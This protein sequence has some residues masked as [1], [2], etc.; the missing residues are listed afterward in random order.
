[1]PNWVYNS[2]HCHGSE[3]DLDALAAFFEMEV[4]STTYDPK[5]KTDNLVTEKVPF[6]YQA[7]RNPFAEPYNIT[8][9]EYH[10]TNGFV[11]GERVGDTE[12]N[13]Y[14]WNSTHW[15]VKWDACRVDVERSDGLITYHFESPWG[16]PWED[17]MLELS[18]R[19]PTIAFTHR[20][21]EE[22]GWGGEY[23]FQNGQITEE[24]QWDIPTTHAEHMELDQT[25]SCE[26]WTD[27]PDMWYADCPSKI[28][29][30]AKE[31]QDA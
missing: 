8:P 30:D 24:M 15:G 21:D 22:Q 20:Y 13:W 1:M 29:H 3:A 31:L 27:D 14:N 7:M 17:M 4:E 23:E 18:E 16:P 5:T 25:C 28:E 26:I 19:F 10:G 12:G 2:L 11:N 6:T 9:E